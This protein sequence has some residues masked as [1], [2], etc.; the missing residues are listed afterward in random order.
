MKQSV[1]RAVVAITEIERQRG[2][3][4][5]AAITGADRAE[6][7]RVREGEARGAIGLK[8]RSGEHG[9]SC[10]VEGAAGNQ[11]A[12]VW[13]EVPRTGSG[14]RGDILNADVRPYRNGTAAASNQDGR[15]VHHGRGYKATPGF[16]QDD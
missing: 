15:G 12:L 14:G 1:W 8:E 9:C 2:C 10:L 6:A 11:I 5:L 16:R 13:K 3:D 7:A 4:R